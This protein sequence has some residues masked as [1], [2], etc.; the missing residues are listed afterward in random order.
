M[1]QENS[2][3][4]VQ[5]VQEIKMPGYVESVASIVR[6]LIQAVPK[7]ITANIHK[8]QS[9]NPRPLSLSSVT[10]LQS[11]TSLKVLQ[12]HFNQNITFLNRNNMDKNDEVTKIK[13][14]AL[15]TM[16]QENLKI[17]NK[18]IVSQLIQELLAATTLK[19]TTEKLSSTFAEIKNEHTRVFT[20]ILSSAIQTA[21]NNIGFNQIKHEVVS[22][23]LT[24]IIATNTQG[25]NLISEIHT[26]KQK[27][28]D[29]LSELEGITDNS[30]NK[31]MND[32][33]KQLEALG[34]MAERKDRKPTGGI[35]QM[36][37]VQKLQK[38]RNKIKREFVDEQVITKTNKNKIVQY[39]NNK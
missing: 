2:Y 21:S 11:P 16:Q 10:S 33:N 14:A 36:P 24:R 37:Y 12:N 35:A 32:F 9:M 19:Q 6:D 38:Q 13:T 23:G 1:S 5:S 29:I 28:V 20:N 39:I 18:E 34:I 26:D 17:E 3:Y 30:C 25:Y 22:P 27:R 7:Q 31:I 4:Q 8:V 15:I